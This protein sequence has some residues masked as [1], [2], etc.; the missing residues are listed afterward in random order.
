MQRLS[1]RL[2]YKY[3]LVKRP[4]PEPLDGQQDLGKTRRQENDE[5][6]ELARDFN[7][8][9]KKDDRDSGDDSDDFGVFDPNK[10]VSFDEKVRFAD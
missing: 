6:D 7:Q 1:N 10:H 8:E 9:A 5:M 4:V 3:N 2:L